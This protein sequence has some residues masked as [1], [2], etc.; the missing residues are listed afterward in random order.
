MSNQH[1]HLLKKCLSLAKK[2]QRKVSPNPMV[3]AVL[4]YE[5][6]IIGEGHHQ[7]FGG[8]H[9]EINAIKDA[10]ENGNRELIKDSTLYVNLEPCC[11]HGKTPPCID[12]IMENNIKH[13][14]IGMKDPNPR[15]S[16]NGIQKL[17]EAGVEV[18]LIEMPEAKELNKVFIK[19]ITTS[20]PYI[21]LK[22]AITK[23]G[24]LT[25][26]KGTQT[27]LTT[28]KEDIQ[29]HRLRAQYD[30]I[31]VGRRTVE[32]DNPRL[33]CRLKELTNG[34]E[35]GKNPIR[36]I[37]DSKGILLTN[38]KFQNLNIFKEKG[39]TI[40]ATTNT[41]SKINTYLKS[42]MTNSSQESELNLC[43]CRSNDTGKVDLKDLLQKLYQQGIYSILVE[44]GSEIIQSFTD[45]DLVDETTVFESKK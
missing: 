25:I 30:G 7:Q 3:G 34:S 43:T 40:I 11:H 18:I 23:D 14:V 17:K 12:R 5:N 42:K 22:F 27:K 26:K 13:V 41:D 28:P 38:N 1:L 31:L 4:A 45:Q 33:T 37:L 10:I 6:K 20:L 16:G 39:K 19:N 29:V 24:K 9:A 15:I 2:D 8:P 32:I 44:G 21:H 35:E 36:I